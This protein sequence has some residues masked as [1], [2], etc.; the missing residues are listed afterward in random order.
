MVWLAI[1]VAY[2]SYLALVSWTGRG[3]R[4]ARLPLAASAAFAWIGWAAIDRIGDPSTWPVTLQIIV[5]ALV[6]VA[7]YRLSGLLFVGADLRMERW[8]QTIDDLT[9]VR[10]GWLARY[11]RAPRLLIEY[12]EVSYLTVYIA[13][14][15]GAT[16]LA[17]GGH[18]DAIARYWTVVLLAEFACYGMLPWIQTRPP[19]V[20]E[21]ASPA[22]SMGSR[23]LN[24][25]IVR[26]ASIQANTVPSG[27]AAGA[28]AA[29]LAVSSVM[30]A[31][32]V[33]FAVAAASIVIAT[34]LGRYHYL[35]DSLLGIAVAVGAWLLV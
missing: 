20:L 15:A 26:H 1:A 29:A 21:P 32:S 13:V 27:H 18:A 19:R 4:R 8:L 14:P 16:V 30:P 25:G 17:L 6:L 5:P 2:L 7:G 11:R 28:V 12:V 23:R 22:T 35:V 31:T 34:V 3:F 10:P 24:L 9:L 33:V